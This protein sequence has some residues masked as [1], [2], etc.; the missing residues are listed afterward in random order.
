MTFDAAGLGG[1]HAYEPVGFITCLG[2]KEE[3]VSK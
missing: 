3:D 2:S 1:I